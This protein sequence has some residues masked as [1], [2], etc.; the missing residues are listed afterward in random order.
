M[1]LNNSIAP[2]EDILTEVDNIPAELIGNQESSYI[3]FE[4][5]LNFYNSRIDSE[6]YG[7]NKKIEG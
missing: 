7:K 6:L 4:E 3:V 2:I 5:Y 1:S